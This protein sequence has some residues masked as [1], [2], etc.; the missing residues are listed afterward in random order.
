MPGRLILC[1]TPIGN[2]GDLSERALQ[3][4]RDAD[5]IACED[6]RR[7]RKLLTHFGVSPK[8]LVVYNDVNEGRQGERL[9]IRIDT[10]TDVVLVSDA[11]MPGLSD[12]GF[13]LVRACVERGLGVQVVPGP[14]AVVAALAVSGLPPGR[15]VFEGFLPRKKSDR[16]R[17]MAEL[18]TEE[19]TVVLFESPHRLEASIADLLEVVGD[20]Y[21]AIARELTKLYEEVRRGPLSEILE[22]LKANPARGEVVIV[23]EGARRSPDDVPAAELA[24][25]ARRLMASGVE[26]KTALASVAKSAG[27]SKKR[28]FDALIDD[29]S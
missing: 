13:R 27:V 22:G 6:T 10:G 25:S 7:T 3:T 24:S 19:R 4:L 15:F 29:R 9:L 11:G 21:V 20:R 16:R 14:S 17:R 23:M 28:V 5:V 8:E 12:P 18:A 2:L 1:G 26:R